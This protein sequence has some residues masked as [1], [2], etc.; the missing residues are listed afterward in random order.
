M[1]AL[2]VFHRLLRDGNSQFIS[3]LKYKSAVFNLRS[4][5]DVS[6]PEAHYQSVFINKYGQYLEEKVLVY[7]MLNVEF[8]KDPNVTKTFNMDESFEKVPRLQSQVNALLNCRASKN[9][10]NNPII[11]YG[12]T[13]LLKDSFK[14]YR[15]LN[16]AI[17]HLLEQYFSMSKANA[18]KSLDI[19]KLFTKETDGIIQ[20][21]D[22]TRKFS[23]TDLPELQHAP[24]T[25]VEALENYIRDFDE[26][27][28]T[29]QNSNERGKKLAQQMDN[30]FT[31]DDTNFNA[32][33]N[34]ADDSDSDDEKTHPS[35]FGS[36]FVAQPKSV[37][38]SSQPSFDPFGIEAETNRS[39]DNLPTFSG[40]SQMNNNPNLFFDDPFGPISS[41]PVNNS[42]DPQYLAKQ[43]QIEM[44][45][46]QNAN[47]KPLAPTS[48]NN[49]AFS[50]PNPTFGSNSTEINT[51]TPNIGSTNS[52]FNRFG[53]AAF[54]F[55]GFGTVPTTNAPNSLPFGTVNTQS[56]PFTTPDPV[57]PQ[58]QKNNNFDFNPFA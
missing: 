34:H 53:N 37:N 27:K 56:N 52:N 46:A 14:L 19:Y 54:G 6:S 17:I 51:T 31:F 26:G 21:F 39:S 58:Q 29:G 25:L 50:N 32:A 2:E 47:L 1:K 13:L 22:I 12:F 9:H 38:N 5:K 20:F 43:K 7:K 3:D 24:T 49:F 33:H 28:D 16:D 36:Q 4:F 57:I 11:V 10:I 48:T 42:L 45:M 44:V 15:A 23:K 30:F 41:Q 18:Q 8:E 55:T 40:N 35:D